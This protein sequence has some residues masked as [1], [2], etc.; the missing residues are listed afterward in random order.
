MAKTQT[1][2]EPPP[3]P[4]AEPILIPRP[5]MLNFSSN[6]SQHLSR[7]RFM[8]L[9]YC[10]VSI[11][12]IVALLQWEFVSHSKDLSVFFLDNSLVCI[13]CMLVSIPLLAIF[14]LVR[15]VRYLPILGWLLV[16]VIVG[17]TVTGHYCARKAVTVQISGRTFGG[18]YLYPGSQLQR[19]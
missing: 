9:V 7:S 4:P 12:L 3:P 17:R 16:L 1:T 13:V 15:K 10:L 5:H 8:V 11:L 6:K 2:E 14:L 19:L 18:W